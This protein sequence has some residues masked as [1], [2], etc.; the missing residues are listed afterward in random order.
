MAGPGASA[1]MAR[2]TAVLMPAKEKSA[3]STCS[4]SRSK[5]RSRPCCHGQKGCLTIEVPVCQQLRTC[6]TFL[7][8]RAPTQ[9]LGTMSQHACNPCKQSST[10][11]IRQKRHS[12]IW[13]TPVTCFFIGMRNG[14]R[15][16]LPRRAS[17]SRHAP[18]LGCMSSPSSRAILSYASPDNS[19]RARPGSRDDLASKLSR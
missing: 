4:S 5:E 16:E 3:L 2:R 18:P 12:A 13:C 1:S 11:Q 6:S 10:R 8:A 15:A 9:P 7:H 19:P 17:A 14:N